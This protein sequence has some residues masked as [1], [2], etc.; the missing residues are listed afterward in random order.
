M[1][2]QPVCSW[3]GQVFRAKR[4]DSLFCNPACKQRYWRWKHKLNLLRA[5]AL[6]VLDEVTGYLDQQNTHMEAV[7]VLG[8][9]SDRLTDLGFTS[10]SLGDT[11]TF[12]IAMPEEELGGQ[13][14]L[15][16]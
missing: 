1:I 7:I 10:T 9:I 13:N 8:E 6:A 2:G 14:D 5:Q 3:C 16:A 12:E 11:P 15:P 4:S